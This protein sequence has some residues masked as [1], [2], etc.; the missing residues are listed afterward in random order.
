[1]QMLKAGILEIGDV[2]VVNKADL[3][4]ADRTV[5]EVKEMIDMNYE[6]GDGGD[7]GDGDNIWTPEVIKTVAERGE[8]NRV[9]GIGLDVR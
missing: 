6:S 4:G 1:V 5:M 9:D 2:F 7:E 8:G 3:K